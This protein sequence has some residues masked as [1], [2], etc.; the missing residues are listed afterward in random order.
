[1]ALANHFQF[2]KRPDPFGPR[3]RIL[4]C[5]GCLLCWTSQIQA[6]PGLIA[7]HFKAAASVALK[8]RNLHVEGLRDDTKHSKCYLCTDIKMSTFE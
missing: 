2:M 4:L 1:M 8:E 6:E 7:D 5:Y 3:L